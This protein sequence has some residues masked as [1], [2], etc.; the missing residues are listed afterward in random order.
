MNSIIRKL[1]SMHQDLHLPVILPIQNLVYDMRQ[2]VEW[3]ADYYE[4]L[5][6]VVFPLYLDVG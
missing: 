5:Y 1:D 4:E 6:W 2:K 3:N